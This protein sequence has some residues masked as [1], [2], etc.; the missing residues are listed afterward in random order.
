MAGHQL[1]AARFID[2]YYDGQSVATTQ[3]GYIS[4]WHDGPL[5]DFGGLGDQ[6]VL[7]LPGRGVDLWDEIAERRGVRV[8]VV[9]APEA[10]RSVPPG[11]VRAGSFHLRHEPVTAVNEDLEVFAT[12]ADELA[13]L[14]RHLAEFAAEVPD[15]V[16]VR[17]NEFAELQ[18][19]AIEADPP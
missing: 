15:G 12:S 9:Y 16:E 19:A 2:R 6:E 5:T 8:A 7:D 3:L 11:W 17:L 13:P 4:L 14:Q 1:Q 18:V 10:F